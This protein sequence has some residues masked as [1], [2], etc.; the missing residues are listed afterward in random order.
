MS[1]PGPIFNSASRRLADD[2][3][4]SILQVT[5]AAP[6][7]GWLSTLMDIQALPERKET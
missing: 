6:G 2:P 7:T 4:A 5:Q 1:G 3:R